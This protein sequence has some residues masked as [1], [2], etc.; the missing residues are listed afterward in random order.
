MSRVLALAPFD[1]VDLLLNLQTLEVIELRFMRLELGVEFV[2]ASFF[3]IRSKR[4]NEQTNA[5]VN[6]IRLCLNLQ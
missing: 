3:L 6:N 5:L 4:L 2:F 1:L